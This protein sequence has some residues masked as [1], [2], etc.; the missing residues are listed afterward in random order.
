MTVVPDIEE[1]DCTVRQA[2]RADLLDVSRI[3]RSLFAQP[4]TFS[5]FERFLGE[6]GFLVAEQ[7][8]VQ[9]ETE[10]IVSEN[11]RPSNADP[12]EPTEAARRAVGES[13]DFEVIGYVVSDVTPNF[14]RN[15]GHVKDLAVRPDKQGVGIGRR[16]LRRAL[17][18]LVVQGAA[19][20]K[21][22][23]RPSNEAA[24]GLYRSEGFEPLRR[25]PGYYG[26]GEAALVML[27]NLDAWNPDRQ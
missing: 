23:V 9:S 7:N 16:L 19:V 14:G 22:E 2:D 15:I 1:S 17:V 4:W 6:M 21:L 20:A 5:V 12:G 26:D 27:V 24:V 25:V 11:D 3:E 18:T 8:H 10:T 13:T